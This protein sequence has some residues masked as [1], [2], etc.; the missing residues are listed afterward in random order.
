[1]RWGKTELAPAAGIAIYVRGESGKLAAAR[2][3]DDADPPAR[4]TDV[5]DTR[6]TSRKERRMRP[7]IAP[8]GTFRDYELRDHTSVPRRLSELQGD[9]PMILTLTRCGHYCPKEDRQHLE[10]AALYPRS[11]WPT[12]RA[13][14]DLDSGATLAAAGARR[15]VL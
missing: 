4:S 6:I 1:V 2:I 7:D 3:Y 5:G 8:G 13:D 15:S 14:L 10:L 9:D 11:P 12:P